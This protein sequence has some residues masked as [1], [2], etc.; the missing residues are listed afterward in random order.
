[1][2]D[3]NKNILRQKP[4]LG[5]GGSKSPLGF[6]VS[7]A[8]RDLGV[9]LGVLH[10]GNHYKF[11]PRCAAPG[12]FN[13]EDLSFKCPVCGFHF[14]M[15]SAAAVMAVIFNAQGELLIVKRGVEPS[16]GMYDIPGGFVDPGENAETALLREIQEELNLKPSTISFYTSFPNQ[17]HYSGTIVFTVDLVFKCA[18]TNFSEMKYGDDIMGIEF[19]KPEEIDLDLVPF[20]SAK[21][22]IQKLIYER[23]HQNTD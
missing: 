23:N 19:M 8:E 2:N 15:N 20:D 11:C 14:F 21:N 5:G 3:N 13:N 1:M 16:I 4:P 6:D 22:L 10:P 12:N 9:D 17:Y 7:S 18:V